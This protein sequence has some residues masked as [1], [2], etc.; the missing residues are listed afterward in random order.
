M[1]IYALVDCNHFYVSCERAFAPYLQNQPV[2]ILSNNDGCLVALSPELKNLGVTRGT[3]GF[4]INEIVKNQKVY[5]F[6]SNYELYGDMS[7]R[8]MKIL[9][10]MVNDIEIY[11]IDEAFLFIDNISDKKI[12]YDL[13][14]EIKKKVYQFTSIP[15]SIGLA[16]TKTLAKI[17]TNMAKKSFNG[18]FELLDENIEEN[19]LKSTSIENIWGI[20]RNYTKRLNKYG[21][22]TG[23]DFIKASPYLIRKEMGIVGERSQLELKGTP[24]SDMTTLPPDTKSIICSRSFGKP[25]SSY[26]KL[27]ETVSTYCSTAV[28]NLREKGL[29]A[30]NLT[31]FITTNPFKDTKQYANYINCSLPDYTAYT[32]EFL[33]L[34]AILLKKIFKENYQY[35]KSG[36]M[37]TDIIKQNVIQPNLFSL[38]Y[39]DDKRHLVMRVMDKINNKF[40]TEKIYFASNGVKKSWKMKREKTSKRFT[41]RWDELMTVK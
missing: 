41:T 17:A 40:G 12:V 18:I 7:T 25:V 15:I 8:V 27:L 16:K 9:A 5:L 28:H 1:Q 14:L 31:L 33:N 10:S 13:A 29:V 37:L 23:Y 22:F 3:P 19:L 24:C 36:I 6:S 38:S 4:K 30:K 20:G 26:E 35:K 21:I 11:S 32:P 39:G 34:C 2:G